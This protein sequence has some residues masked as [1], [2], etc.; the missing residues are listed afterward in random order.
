[1]RK[2][3]IAALLFDLELLRRSF[4]SWARWKLSLNAERLGFRRAV[5]TREP[6]TTG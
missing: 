5:R 1:M 2:S 4:G 6:A 3:P